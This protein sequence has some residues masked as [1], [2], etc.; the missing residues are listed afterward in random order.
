MAFLAVQSAATGLRE[1]GWCCFRLL[2]RISAVRLRRTARKDLGFEFCK[3][4]SGQQNA[5]GP[6]GTQAARCDQSLPAQRAECAKLL[7]CAHVGN[8]A[9]QPM[10]WM[11][12]Q[13]IL[14]THPKEQQM[15]PRMRILPPHRGQESLLVA[16]HTNAPSCS[17]VLLRPSHLHSSRAGEAERT[18]R[19]HLLHCTCERSP[20]R[21]NPGRRYQHT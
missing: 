13:S 8:T 10:G 19:P 1:G 20:S 5:A 16:V 3:K 15:L 21:P 18:N 2:G 11:P 12:T 14:K 6:A 7:L 17:V 9:R 4:H